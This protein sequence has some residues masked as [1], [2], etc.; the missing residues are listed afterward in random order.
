MQSQNAN[1]SI[2]NVAYAE[3]STT[4]WTPPSY[5]PRDT[6]PETNNPEPEDPNDPVINIATFWDTTND[7]NYAKQQIHQSNLEYF[8]KSNY[9]DVGLVLKS[10]SKMKKD[11]TDDPQYTEQQPSASNCEYFPLHTPDDESD[12]EVNSNYPISECEDGS[13]LKIYWNAEQEEA[14]EASCDGTESDTDTSECDAK[15]LLKTN[16][17]VEPNDPSGFVLSEVSA[18]PFEAFSNKK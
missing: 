18:D 14:C 17:D 8:Q 11:W 5:S 10:T 2:K 9:G 4:G 6:V 1:E 7:P 12:T 15:S 3:K 16:C 13:Q